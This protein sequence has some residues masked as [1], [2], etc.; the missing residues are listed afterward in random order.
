MR[1]HGD[2]DGADVYT[3]HNRWTDGR[4]LN[5]EHYN[6]PLLQCNELYSLLQ[7][8]YI[9]GCHIHGQVNYIVLF[10][11]AMQW[12]HCIFCNVTYVL[13]CTKL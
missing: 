9:Q 1:Q 8:Q 5:V 6:A 11:N 4:G 12:L 3:N 2:G 10:C 7:L 13:H